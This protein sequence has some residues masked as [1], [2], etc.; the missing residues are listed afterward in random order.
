[1]SVELERL[2]LRVR[3][4]HLQLVY[5]PSPAT[6]DG[7]YYPSED[8]YRVVSSISLALFDKAVLAAIN[9]PRSLE[10]PDEE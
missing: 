2:A 9:G 7:R 10:R 5:S 6:S 4:H 1:V 3:D 8:P